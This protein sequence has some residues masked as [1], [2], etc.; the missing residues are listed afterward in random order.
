MKILKLFF[1]PNGRIGRAKYIFAMSILLGFIIV[2]EIALSVELFMSAKFEQP[3]DNLYIVKSSFFETRMESEPGTN[4]KEKAQS[5]KFFMDT[6]FFSMTMDFGVLDFDKVKE[7]NEKPAGFW[8][9]FKR[10]QEMQE[11]MRD[12]AK[13]EYKSAMVWLILVW[14]LSTWVM[15]APTV[16]RMHDLNFR[17]WWLLLCFMATPFAMAPIP[18]AVLMQLSLFSS[19]AAFVIMIVTVFVKGTVGPNRFGPDPLEKSPAKPEA[20]TKNVS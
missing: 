18:Y 16:K 5:T 9:S 3:S 1:S 4:G 2:A 10:Q 8:E 15:V 14:L 7:Q 19:L 17:G 20:E 11:K 6:P 13:I 12:M